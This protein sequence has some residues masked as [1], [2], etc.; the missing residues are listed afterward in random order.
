M[1]GKKK[2]SFTLIELVVVMAIIGILSVVGV[3]SYNSIMKNARD[4]KRKNDLKEIQVALENYKVAHGTYPRNDPAESGGAANAI[5]GWD[6]SEKGNF[7]NVLLTEGF[8]KQQPKD[9]SPQDETYCSP[10]EKWGYRY[11]RY[12]DVDVGISDCGRYHYIIAAH[13]ENDGNANVDQVPQCYVQKG[14]LESN[15]FGIGEFE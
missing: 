14:D 12:R 10:P 9:P 11:Y 6:V 4:A 13:M 3:Y 15:Y 7:I 8:L 5:C 1:I 2:N